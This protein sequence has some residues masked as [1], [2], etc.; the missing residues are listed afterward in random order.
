MGF[1][2]NRNCYKIIIVLFFHSEN[3]LLHSEKKNIQKQTTNSLFVLN[4][5]LNL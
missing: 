5:I 3:K 1:F 2:V 4:K